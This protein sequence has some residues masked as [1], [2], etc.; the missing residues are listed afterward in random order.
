VTPSPSQPD[1]GDLGHHVDECW[2]WRRL[3]VSM[4]AGGSV[5]RRAVLMSVADVGGRCSQATLDLFLIICNLFVDYAEKCVHNFASMV[6]ESTEEL[7]VESIEPEVFEVPPSQS[8][9][10]L[11]RRKVG[12]TKQEDHVICFAFLN[13]IK[14]GTTGMT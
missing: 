13:V 5:R 12:F 8:H 9:K 1:L 11:A 3:A 4:S 6:M 14:D 10:K 2:W 7:L